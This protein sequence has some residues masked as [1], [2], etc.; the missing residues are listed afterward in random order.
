MSAAAQP[1]PESAKT[2]DAIVNEITKRYGAECFIEAGYGPGD[3]LRAAIAAALD[4][5]RREENDRCAFIVD[6]EMLEAEDEIDK[7]DDPIYKR[8]QRATAGT[9]QSLAEEIRSCMKETPAQTSPDAT[10]RPA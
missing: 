7:S 4:A 6:C 5:A 2:A 10:I 9:C 3:D 1:I 8:E